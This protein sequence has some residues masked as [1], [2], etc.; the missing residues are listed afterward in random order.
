MQG[1]V[2]FLAAFAH[3]LVTR[4]ICVELLKASHDSVDRCRRPLVPTVTEA[5][6]PASR[7]QTSFDLVG[8]GRAMRTG[9]LGYLLA[10]YAGD[11]DVRI[12]TDAAE[13]TPRIVSGTGAISTWLHECA[14]SDPTPTVSHL[15][16][17]G[18]RVSFTQQWHNAD[19][20]A[21]L[22]LSTAELL[23]GL[24]TTQH[25]ILIRRRLPETSET[26]GWAQASPR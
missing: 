11:A 21:A 5:G 2:T 15:V 17:G 23:D 16:D 4:Q 3:H 12:T 25:T 9:D 24:I 19:G 18:D 1:A 14:A 8:F 7:D 20:T 10:R 13:C 22:A 6:A 26:D